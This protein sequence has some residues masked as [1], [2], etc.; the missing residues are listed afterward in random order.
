MMTSVKLPLIQTPEHQ[1]SPDYCF[2]SLTL[3]PVRL[4]PDINILSLLF[5]P[6]V[7]TKQAQDQICNIRANNRVMFRTMLSIIYLSVL[8]YILSSLLLGKA[9]S[10]EIT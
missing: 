8:D 5:H 2:F 10:S 1:H 3:L 7:Y 9:L 4:A 6:T